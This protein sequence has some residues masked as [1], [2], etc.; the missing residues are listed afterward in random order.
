MKRQIKSFP[1]ITSK[2]PTKGKKIE[3]PAVK[4]AK[5]ELTKAQKRLTIEIKKSKTTTKKKG[6]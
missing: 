4:A 1:K 2:K 5:K 6:K 3:V